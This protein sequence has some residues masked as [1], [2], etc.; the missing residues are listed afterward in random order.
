MLEVIVTLIFCM[1]MLELLLV[2]KFTGKPE[3]VINE[4]VSIKKI[5]NRKIT[6]VIDDIENADS[7]LCFGVRFMPSE[8][9]V[10]NR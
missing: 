8:V 5:N 7:T 6:S 4:E 10:T 1:T 9:L 3:G 2:G